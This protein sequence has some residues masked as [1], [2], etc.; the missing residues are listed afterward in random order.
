MS[1][2]LPDVI[3]FEINYTDKLTD[4]CIAVKAKSQDAY[5]ISYTADKLITKM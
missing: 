2:N 3:S 5:S 1:Q 4:A